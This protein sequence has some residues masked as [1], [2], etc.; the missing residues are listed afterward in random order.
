MVVCVYTLCENPLMRMEEISDRLRLDED[1]IYFS[2]GAADV[3]YSS[4]G[5][6]ECFGVED[7]SFWFRHRNNCIASMV[8]N[9]PFATGPLLDIGGGNGYVAERLVAEGWSVVLLEPGA[10]GARNA[11]KFRQLEHVVRSKV[12]DAGFFPESF[13]A[14]GMF[15]VIEHIDCDRVF[16]KDIQSLL[17]P[18]GRLYLTVPCHQWLWSQADID[19][20]HFRR[21]TKA[22]LKAL[23]AGLFKIDYLSFYFL[24]LVLPQYLL[25]SLPWRLGLGNSKKLLS[26]QA[27]HGSDNGIA[28]RIIDA[29][30][31][32]E[33]RRI[34][35]G[36]S[37]GFGASCLVAASRI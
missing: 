36:L 21:H 24:P 17:V 13:G 37:I 19:A 1:G 7:R 12:E 6:S 9:H 18:G 35:A 4:H 15:D 22:T 30:L 25:R 34:A 28:V 14:I 29:M 16:L 31:D 32:I 26:T 20:G 27:E 8:R 33:G 10:D 2:S 23:L 11:R 5:N 3:S